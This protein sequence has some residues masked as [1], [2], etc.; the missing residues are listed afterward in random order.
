MKKKLFFLLSIFC[1]NF[2]F[3]P[4]ITYNSEPK[5]F[6]QEL[7]DDAVK[8]LSDNSISQKEKDDV[9]K[10]I[11]LENVDIKALGLYTLG[12]I[13]KDLDESV[14]N[15]Y[16]NLFQE[17]F[18]KSLTSRL[19]D[20]A[21]QKF[22]VIESEQKSSNYTI[23]KSKIAESVKS[24]EIK[25]NWRV[26]TK[27][28][29]KPLIRDLVVEGL[30]LARTQKEEFASILNSNNNDINALLNKLKEFISN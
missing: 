30:S 2:N 4:A 15:N 25:I 20:Y 19:T 24:P 9:I 10:K 22:E 12:Q 5:I 7:V 26:Y 3:L 11:A 17:Y 14:I 28:P 6:I 1:L 27:N 16:Q 18:L 23:V 13:R 21:S 8:T 29:Q